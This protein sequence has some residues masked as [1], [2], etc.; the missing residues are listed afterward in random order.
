MDPANKKP[1]CPES[2][3]R[4]YR[5]ITFFVAEQKVRVDFHCE[6]GKV[7]YHE[8]VLWKDDNKL[9]A[10]P[11]DPLCRVPFQARS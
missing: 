5:K 8:L 11:L 7:T 2:S 10:A 1:Q 3:A 6:E 4:R 9:Q